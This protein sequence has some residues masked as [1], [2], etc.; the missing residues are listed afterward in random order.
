MNYPEFVEINN[1]L[2]KINT[3]FR[4]AIK[5]NEIAEDEN[6]KDFERAMAIIYLLFGDKGLETYDK[7]DELLNQARKFL[8]CN[9]E[10]D[11][12]DQEIDMDYVE[13]MD[14]IEASF[15]SDYHID[16]SNTKMHWWKFYNLLCGLSNS[17]FGNCC[18]LN[19][20]RN[21]RTFDLKQIKDDKERSKIEKAKKQVELKKYKKENNLTEE[22][23]RSLNDFNK[24]FGI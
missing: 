11:N 8:C 21:L 14:Y 23:E 15:M 13:D 20:I 16:L 2:F 6:I 10:F 17:E 24:M 9:K 3:D 1:E 18:V 19:R 4:V 12:E 22:Q 7:Y 5:C